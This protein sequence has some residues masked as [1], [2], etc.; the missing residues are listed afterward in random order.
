[1]VERLAQKG[2][3]SIL[4]DSWQNNSVDLKKVAQVDFKVKEG[5]IHD[6][7]PIK[8]T[9]SNA[10]V[11]S[12][13]FTDTMDDKAKKGIKNKQAKDVFAKKQV[14]STPEKVDKGGWLNGTEDINLR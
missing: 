4:T 7:S 10:I 6:Y 2:G 12:S 1:R 9:S 11:K 3:H 8:K 13:I 5:N 14:E